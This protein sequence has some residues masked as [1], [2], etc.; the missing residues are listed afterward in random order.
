M[1]RE[2]FGREQDQDTTAF[3]MAHSAAAARVDTPIFTYTC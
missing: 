1:I 2:P 3:C